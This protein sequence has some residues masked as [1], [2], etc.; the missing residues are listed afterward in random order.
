MRGQ[1]LNPPDHHV[2]YHEVHHRHQLQ[3]KRI[4][5]NRAHH[6]SDRYSTLLCSI[7]GSAKSRNLK[8]QM[9]TE[10]KKTT[11]RRLE[12]K[13]P[14]T[15]WKLSKKLSYVRRLV[16]SEKCVELDAYCLLFNLCIVETWE[17]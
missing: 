12:R 4:K 9:K 7:G 1:T 13:A 5:D 10:T 17:N 8:V 16:W 11:A 3:I 15:T 2:V 6:Q 14:I